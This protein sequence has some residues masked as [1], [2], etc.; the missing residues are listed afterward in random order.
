MFW[1]SSRS[2]CIRRSDGFSSGYRLRSV[3]N[4][5]PQEV[6][7]WRARTAATVSPQRVVAPRRPR[8]APFAMTSPRRARLPSRKFGRAW[9]ALACRTENGVVDAPVLLANPLPRRIA[10]SLAV[11]AGVSPVRLSFPIRNLFGSCAAARFL[12]A[13]LM[14]RTP[15]P[16][17]MVLPFRALWNTCARRRPAPGRYCARLQPADTRPQ[18]YGPALGRFRGSNQWS[19]C[20]AVIPLTA[21]SPEVPGSTSCTILIAIGCVLRDLHS[22]G[23]PQRHLAN[24]QQRP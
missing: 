12:W 11:A 1:G 15:V 24:A 2:L 17:M 9:K 20:S 5:V 8:F 7:A 6:C 23:A 19:L 21:I 16:L 3:L 13:G 14:A 22:G 10:R 4:R 18:G